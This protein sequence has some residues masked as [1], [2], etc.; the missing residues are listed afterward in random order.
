MTYI[1]NRKEINELCKE[2]K[3]IFDT[4]TELNNNNYDTVIIELQLHNVSFNLKENEN[5]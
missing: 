4:I 2:D 5:V 1:N 3:V